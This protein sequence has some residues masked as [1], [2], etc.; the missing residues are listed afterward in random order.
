[1]WWERGRGLSTGG[2]GLL[3]EWVV[4]A[5]GPG[6]Q[7]QT[8]KP[9]CF[10]KDS[11]GFWKISTKWAFNV[12]NISFLQVWDLII[13]ACNP[14]AWVAEVYLY[15]VL[16]NLSISM[17]TCNWNPSLSIHFHCQLRKIKTGITIKTL[18][19][20]T[21]QHGNSGNKKVEVAV[22]NALQYTP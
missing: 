13:I 1:M 10:P 6:R 11:K 16:A 5:W 3:Q 19:A 15:L 9:Q 14:L 2:V 17:K 8:H 20:A 12:S 18:E 22:K 4:G 21:S 7:L